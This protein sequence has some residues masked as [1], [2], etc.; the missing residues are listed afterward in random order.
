MNLFLPRLITT[1]NYH[2]QVADWIRRVQ[3]VGVSNFVPSW[4]T[5]RALNN[6]CG[7]F[8]QAG[9][10]TKV[11]SL[12]CF[13]PD[14]ITASFTALISTYGSSS[15]RNS[16]FVPTDLTIN[17]LKGAT[18]K[19]LCTGCIPSV[20]FANTA[21]GGA[22]VYTTEGN[23]AGAGELGCFGAAYTSFTF[24][25]YV[26][27]SDEISYWDC[28][29]AGTGRGRVSALNPIWNGFLSGNRYADT[30][31]YIA[32]GGGQIDGFQIF[33][34]GSGR[35]NQLLNTYPAYCMT[36][37]QQNAPNASYYSTKRISFAAIHDG[38][39]PDECRL[40]SYLVQKM[41]IEMGGGYA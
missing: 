17:G 7:E 28:F 34:S 40:F 4:Q 2:S 19:Y 30:A 5:A 3:S 35:S 37:A 22:S 16:G 9:L 29:G 8:F 6:F 12:N 41:R 32:R 38:Y 1:G 13:V 23:N 31:S 36:F 24:C 25:L 20:V 21:S 39:T 18:N 11:K 15:W 26:D 27:W 14:N 10:N 33:V